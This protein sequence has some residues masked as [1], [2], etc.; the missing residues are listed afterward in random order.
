MSD[1]AGVLVAIDGPAGSGKSTVSKLVAK[2]LGLAF[3]DTGAMYRG[4]T[5]A[6]LRA[7]IPLDSVDLVLEEADKMNFRF[8]GTV[9]EPRFYLGEDEVTV[10]IRESLV[11]ANV[12]T[13]AGLIPVRNWMALEQRRQMLTARDSGAGMVAEGRDIT[14]VVCPD[15]DVRVLLVASPDARI[16]RRTLEMYGEV[17]AELLEKTRA[18]VEGRD[19]IDSRVSEFLEPAEGVTVIDSSNMTI[20]EVVDTVIGMVSQIKG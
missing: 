4:L 18:L 7:G 2:R 10:Q 1:N 6:C 8:E 16:R 11:A 15:A 9:D 20:D 12:S 17:T 5:L 13:V 19:Q 14:T 3:L